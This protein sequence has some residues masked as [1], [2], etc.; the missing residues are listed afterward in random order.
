M[1]EGHTLPSG[2]FF[3]RADTV[4]E[5]ALEALDAARGP[6]QFFWFH[7]FDAHAP[8]GSSRGEGWME[9]DVFRRLFDGRR[10]L[11]PPARDD[12]AQLERFRAFERELA[13]H[14]AGGALDPAVEQRLRALGYAP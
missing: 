8:Y 14:T 11:G 6:R 1:W 13:E 4:T 12:A 5:H 2:R 7:S 3:S 9:S 10:L